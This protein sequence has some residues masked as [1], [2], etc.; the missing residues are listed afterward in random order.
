MTLPWGRQKIYQKLESQVGNTPLITIKKIKVPNNNIIFAKEEWLNPTSSLF[1]RV[2]PYLFRK[3]EEA[4]YIVPGVTPVI[5]ASTGNAGAAFAWCAQELGYLDCTVITHA[6]TPKA[7]V[8]QIKSYGAKVLFSPAGEYAR[9]YVRLLERILEDD[10]KK[11]GGKIGVNT[12]RLYCVTKINPK[13]KVPLRQLVDEIIKQVG[14][15]TIDYFICV[16]GSG[17]TI[18]GIGERLKEVY[19][20]I[21]IIALE[22]ES[23]EV[24]HYLQKGK[25]YDTEKLPHQLYA[26][27]PFGLP[28]EKLDINFSI[29]DEIEKINDNDWDQ[30]MQ[31]LETLEHKSV[32]RSSGA[33]LSAA[34]KIAQK[35]QRKKF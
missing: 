15:K 34:L 10:R 12:K 19:P 25:V 2:Y 31:L 4:G 30:G 24:L 23:T 6:D 20:T 1:G 8:E 7:R 21:K 22:H 13:A 29:I 14:K 27:A 32:G 18:S 9:G 3:A 33:S 28:A 17:T 35:V 11:K 26:S 5:E 16:V